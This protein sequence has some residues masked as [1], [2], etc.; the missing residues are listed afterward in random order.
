MQTSPLFQL[1]IVRFG[2]V[3]VCSTTLDVLSATLLHRAGM[4]AA[5]ATAIGF[6]LGFALGFIL[7]SQFVFQTERTLNRTIKY[8]AISLG[9]L[10]ISELIIYLLF[11]HGHLTFLVSKLI[12]VVVVFFW[13]YV[14]SRIWAFR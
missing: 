7:N 8:L 14:L 13:N 5:L 6:L 4:P 11:T 12:A 1:Q 10:L 3:G 9:G 2:I